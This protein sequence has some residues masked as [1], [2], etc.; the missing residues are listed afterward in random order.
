MLKATESRFH[1]PPFL[2]FFWKLEHSFLVLNPWFIDAKMFAMNEWAVAPRNWEFIVN[3][4]SFNA[5]LG[6]R[7]LEHFHE[8]I[9]PCSKLM[10]VAYIFRIS[11]K[12]R[13]SLML[14]SWSNSEWLKSW[15]FEFGG[16]DNNGTGA[17]F[18]FG[19]RVMKYIYFS[20]L[21][22]SDENVAPLVRDTPS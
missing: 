10:S 12:F 14:N 20:V 22:F 5:N 8:I 19:K 15:D 2:H 3:F 16:E 6:I 17:I 21:H 1:D 4:M 11:E 7:V 18:K 13:T 9:W